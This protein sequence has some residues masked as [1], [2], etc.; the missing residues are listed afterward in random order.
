LIPEL[1]R[2]RGTRAR[3]ICFEIPESRLAFSLQVWVN[4]CPC[5]YARPGLMGSM[6]QAGASLRV[7]LETPR[8]HRSINAICECRIT[9]PGKADESLM[10]MNEIFAE[11]P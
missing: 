9:K 4:G 11:A 8:L 3:A 10:K 2:K 6:D 1:R 5:Y 7:G